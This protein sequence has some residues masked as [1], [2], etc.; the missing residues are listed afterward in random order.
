[1][2]TPIVPLSIRWRRFRLAE[3]D[4][5]D[6][7]SAACYRTPENIGIVAVIV[8][9]LKF[10][11]VQ[12]HI[13]FA[14]LMERADNAAFEDRPKTLNRVG[15]H[16]ANNVLFCL[17][18]D[19]LARI[20]LQAVID[21]VLIGRQQTNF[22]RYHLADE[23][24]RSLLGDAA[25]DA[26]NNIA[27]TLDCANDCRFAG[28]RT[29]SVAV[30]AFIPVT[31]LVLS[32]DPC[33]VNLNNAA[34]LLLGRNQG[35]ADFVAHGMGRLVGAEA[36]HALNLE[37]AHSLLTG[38]HQMGDPVPVAE[39]LLGV[40]EDGPGH[41]REAIAILVARAT[42][43]MKRLVARGVVQVRIAA[44][45]AMDAL[46]PTAGNQVPLAGLLVTNWEDR[47]KLGR[48]HLRNWLRTSCHGGYPRNLSVGGYCHA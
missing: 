3:T 45:R 33:F 28:S 41:D 17:V 38:E 36:H 19:S 21:C 48:G 2:R 20:F 44:A 7:V 9:E 42:L 25:K 31:V 4:A 18:L 10:S 1:M 12:R 47:L 34:K 23:R 27:L 35:R 15:M 22:L 13:F 14:D 24:F 32:A 29:A 11:D 30:V 40:F 39:R 6:L 46:R 16:R 26:S 43:P 37:G 5:S 8:S